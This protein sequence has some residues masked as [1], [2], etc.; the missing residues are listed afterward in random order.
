MVR[1]EYP[2]LYEE[3]FSDIVA[4]EG[5][6]KEM[7]QPS[8][9]RLEAVLTNGESN[10][11]FSLKDNKT[12]ISETERRLSD[13]DGFVAIEWA[14]GVFQRDPN[15]MDGG[16]K[17]V[18]PFVND[19]DFTTT[20]GYNKQHINRVFNG[21]LIVEKGGSKVIPAFY[22]GQFYDA[23]ETQRT[24]ATNNSSKRG[25]EAGRLLLKP[26]LRL[27]GSGQTDI[28]IVCPKIK[29]PLWQNTTPSTDATKFVENRVALFLFGYILK[30]KAK[31]GF[32]K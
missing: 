14:L 16:S 10:I 6:A 9:L 26:Q 31:E 5:I 24:A 11:E 12:G 13:S 7:V 22:T 28:K 23:P 17:I 8:F 3:I 15:E 20:A 21:E 18:Q 29:N 19:V 27:Y 30:D 25:S 1:N 2:A 32:S 4:T